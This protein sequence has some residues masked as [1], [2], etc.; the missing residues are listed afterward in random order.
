[1]NSEKS[2]RSTDTPTTMIQ[3]IN[4]DSIDNEHPAKSLYRL[5]STVL[6][7]LGHKQDLIAQLSGDEQIFDSDV[8]LT[9]ELS[10]NMDDFIRKGM[11]P[12]SLQRN[13]EG[14]FGESEGS[15]NVTTLRLEKEMNIRDVLEVFDKTGQLDETINLINELRTEKDPKAETIMAYALGQYAKG[16]MAEE[17]VLSELDNISKGSVSNDEGGIDFYLNGD[18]AQLGSITRVNSKKKEMEASDIRHLIYQWTSDGELVVGDMDDVMAENKK[19]AKDA[20]KSTV[21]I[22]RSAGN[23]KINEKAGRRFRYLWW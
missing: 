14:Y 2:K 5:V 6:D 19:I 7:D 12:F 1:V 18:M 23:L 3:T 16:W 17:I 10:D 4:I 9:L 13:L 15:S 22:R 8:G 11:I 21:L 20:G